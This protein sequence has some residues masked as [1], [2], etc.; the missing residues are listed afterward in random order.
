MK[1]QK[2]LLP[3]LVVVM[4]SVWFTTG[5]DTKDTKLP[6]D[7]GNQNQSPPM[8]PY[9]LIAIAVSPTEIQ[10]TWKDQSDNETGFEIFESINNDTS[11]VRI[12]P[13]V[14]RDVETVVLTGKLREN[15]YYYKIRAYN[16]FGPSSFSNETDVRGGAKILEIDAGEGAVLSVAFSPHGNYIV[17]G[18]SDYRIRRYNAYTGDLLQTL[19]VHQHH[20]NSVA[21]SPDSLRIASASDDGTVKVWNTKPDQHLEYTFQEDAMGVDEVEFS[22]DNRYLASGGY[23]VC[24]WDLED[25]SL[26]S[27]FGYN[28]TTGG[29][30][31][32]AY[33]PNGRYIFASG[34]DKIE[35]WDLEMPES[36]MYRQRTVGARSLKVSSDGMFLTGAYV[37]DVWI[38]EIVGEGDD[39]RV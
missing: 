33:H 2:L 28:D 37:D 19:E 14:E 13:V 35:I 18:C 39:M 38:W 6:T 10:L 23:N 11:Y 5:C 9:D 30:I 25:G 16:G 1:I 21:Y 17:A 36:F 27:K 22:P 4:A 12:D 3:V 15:D 31:S 20:V 24:I 7:P 32:F 26:V 29:I 8:P 34:R